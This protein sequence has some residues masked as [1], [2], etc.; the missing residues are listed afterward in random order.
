MGQVLHDVVA[1][2]DAPSTG[3]G[4][5]ANTPNPDPINAL[6]EKLGLNGFFKSA[7][8]HNR[9]FT[10]SVIIAIIMAAV[11]MR[12]LEPT[13]DD[14]LVPGAKA[15]EQMLKTELAVY[16]NQRTAEIDA[17]HKEVADMQVKVAAAQNEIVQENAEIASVINTIAAAAA[18]AAGPYAPLILAVTGLVTAG[19]GADSVRK[20]SLA[21]QASPSSSGWRPFSICPMAFLR[22]TP[23][24]RSFHG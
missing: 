1:V 3:T 20:T 4:A 15:T 24:A 9:Y 17:I 23:S 16:V 11:A 6:V 13:A 2:H 7:L 19:L 21:N 22:T 10:L 14:P 8:D 12:G 18:P 5:S